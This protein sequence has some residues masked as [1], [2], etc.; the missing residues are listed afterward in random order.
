MYG[1]C[2]DILCAFAFYSW[3]SYKRSGTRIKDVEDFFK[4]HRYCWFHSKLVFFFLS[5]FFF[6]IDAICVTRCVMKPF[7]MQVRGKL[8]FFDVK[9]DVFHSFEFVFCHDYHLTLIRFHQFVNNCFERKSIS[10]GQFRWRSIHDFSLTMKRAHSPNAEKDE[11]TWNWN[12]KEKKMKKKN[13][14]ICLFRVKVHA[15]RDNTVWWGNCQF[16]SF[17]WSERKQQF[18]YNFSVFFFYF[19]I[20]YFY[21]FVCLFCFVLLMKRVFF[22][23]FI[24]K[25]SY[26]LVS[27]H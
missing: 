1:F 23:S 3:R 25:N 21:L 2:F 19:S 20:F 17:D 16:Q 9:I 27:I 12:P 18:N 13:L 4:I 6:S 11:H 10:D 5:L 26:F 8:S 15:K 7:R 24:P 22:F 14:F